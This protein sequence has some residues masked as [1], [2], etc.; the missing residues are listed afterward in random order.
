MVFRGRKFGRVFHSGIRPGAMFGAE[1]TTFPPR[2]LHRLRAQGLRAGGWYKPGLDIDLG[3]LLTEPLR[4]PGLIA[5]EAPLLRLAKEWW[6]AMSC[7]RPR[8]NLDPKVLRQAV[9][10]ALQTLPTQPALPYSKRDKGPIFAAVY[11][12]VCLGWTW[13]G[14]RPCCRPWSAADISSFY[15]TESWRGV[16]SPRALTSVLGAACSAEEA[17]NSGLLRREH[18]LVCSRARASPV[19]GFTGGASSSIHAALFVACATQ[20][21]TGF[22]TARL[23][24]MSVPAL[25]L[26]PPSGKCGPSTGPWSCQEDGLPPFPVSATRPRAEVLH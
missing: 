26:S 3:W 20:S 7:H 24:R 22:G 13:Q 19:T 1:A 23:G 16:I 5:L 6:Y 8:D 21:S 4:D 12:V 15:T 11:S 2:A 14:H 10:K 17:A 25:N 9:Q 18:C